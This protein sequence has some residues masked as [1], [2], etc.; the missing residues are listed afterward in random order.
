ME[1]NEERQGNDKKTERLAKRRE[2]RRQRLLEETAEEREAR[3]GKR[4]EAWKKKTA[5]AKGKQRLV[6]TTLCTN[7]TVATV[8]KLK[9]M[10]FDPLYST[11][12][13]QFSN[14]EFV[15]T[16]SSQYNQTV[17]YLYQL[18]QPQAILCCQIPSVATKGEQ[19]QIKHSLFSFKS[20]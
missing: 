18:S 9:Y 13:S 20:L 15:M 3:L 12:S 10:I 17:F 14:K 7:D 11:I 8:Y 16:R 1:P 5:E 4:R 19:L 6:F 2:R